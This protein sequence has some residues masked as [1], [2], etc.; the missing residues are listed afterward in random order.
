MFRYRGPWYLSLTLPSSSIST[1]LY[2]DH[3]AVCN[4]DD[5]DPRQVLDS[6]ELPV[7]RPQGFHPGVCC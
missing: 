3:D 1:I 6:Q 2:L 5:Q 4:E 7:P